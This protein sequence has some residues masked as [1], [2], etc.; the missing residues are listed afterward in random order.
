MKGHVNGL[1]RPEDEIML[2]LDGIQGKIR[3]S[4]LAVLALL[5]KDGVDDR[6]GL[7]LV[8]WVG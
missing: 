3:M 1:G 8:E 5:I 2:K 6:M 4:A 7:E